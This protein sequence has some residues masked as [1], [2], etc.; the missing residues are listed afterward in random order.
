[1]PGVL[2]HP[3][4]CCQLCKV[5]SLLF[6]CHQ[7]LLLLHGGGSLLLL[8]VELQDL[9]VLLSRHVLVNLHELLQ[10]L[11]VRQL[12]DWVV[13]GHIHTSAGTQKKDSTPDSTVVSCA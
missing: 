6:Q 13:G 1:M 10:L 3:V 2:L 9:C 5:W 4:A 11:L 12:H 8:R 7:Q